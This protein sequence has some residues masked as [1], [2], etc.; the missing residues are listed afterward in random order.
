M[1]HSTKLTSLL[2][3]LVAIF[4]KQDEVIKLISLTRT[5]SHYKIIPKVDNLGFLKI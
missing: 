1:S 4:W 3:S 2:A 5:G